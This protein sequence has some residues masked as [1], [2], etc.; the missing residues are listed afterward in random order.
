MTSVRESL[1][2]RGMRDLDPGEMMRFRRVEEEFRSTCRSWGYSEIRTPVIEHLHLFTSAGTLSPQMLGRVYSFLDWDGWSGER[3]VLRP[4]ATI[5]A[6]RLYWEHFGG[7]IAKLFYVENIFRFAASD[8]QREV[9]QC[10]AELFGD[11]WPLG[12]LELI[13]VVRRVLRRLGFADLRLRLSHTGI[14][15]AILA[16][17]GYTPEEQ[18]LLYDRMLDGDL[19]VFSEIEQRLPQLGAPL[20]LLLDLAGGQR[21]AL[22]N[23]RSA[24]A[25]SVPLMQQ[26]L[27]ELNTIAATLDEADCSYELDLTMVRDFEYYTGPVFQVSIDGQNVASG[28]RYDGLVAAQHGR[29]VPACGFAIF[30]DSLTELMA[31]SSGVVPATAVDVQPAMGGARAMALALRAAVDLQERGVAAELVAAERAAKHRWQIIVDPDSTESRYSVL[32]RVHETVTSAS[33][34]EQVAAALAQGIGA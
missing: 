5:P 6:A 18:L 3:V 12:D 31:E 34:T 26:P 20:R 13:A 14:V 9:W 16:T 23:L 2:C 25:V 7:E 22:E 28:G 15:R 17:A 8:E 32:D 1:R 27:D 30:V 21:G 10:G 33:S 24:F 29:S 19:G 11:T 4:D